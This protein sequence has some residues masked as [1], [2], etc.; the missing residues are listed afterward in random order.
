MSNLRGKHSPL[1]LYFWNYH[2]NHHIN[3]PSLYFLSKYYVPT[4][5]HALS[6]RLTK[7]CT[8][9]TF[10]SLLCDYTYYRPHMMTTSFIHGGQGIIMYHTQWWIYIQKFPACAPPPNR[11]KFFHF[12]ICFHQK[13]PVLELGAP[14]N[15]GWRPPNGK[16]W[17]RP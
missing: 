2:I 16:S 14:S 5:V 9:G 11:T 17:I 15:E 12:Y 4:C 8:P 13:A 7:M 10:D 6:H 3:L 1:F